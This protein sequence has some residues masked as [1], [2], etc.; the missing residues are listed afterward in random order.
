MNIKFVKSITTKITQGKFEENKLIWKKNPKI[1]FVKAY[2]PK[3]APS[4][5]MLMFSCVRCY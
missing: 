4:S 3:Q 1:S 2:F 5:P